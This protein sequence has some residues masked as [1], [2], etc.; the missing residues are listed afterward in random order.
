MVLLFGYAIPLQAN[1]WRVADGSALS[2]LN[3]GTL[4]LLQPGGLIL[5]AGFAFRVF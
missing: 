2:S 5:G 3:E 1:R 4:K